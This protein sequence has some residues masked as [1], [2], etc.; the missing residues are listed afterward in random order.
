MST[1]D[2][3]V[4][5]RSMQVTCHKIPADHPSAAPGHISY[6]SHGSSQIQV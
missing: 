2:P 4:N 6:F 5:L 1:G 3:Q